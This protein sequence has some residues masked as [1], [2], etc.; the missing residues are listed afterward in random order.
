MSDTVRQSIASVYE[1]QGQQYCRWGNRGQIDYVHPSI[2]NLTDFFDF[3]MFFRISFSFIILGPGPFGGP[4]QGCT[5]LLALLRHYVGLGQGYQVY[6]KFLQIGIFWKG[7]GALRRPPLEPMANYSLQHLAWK[8]VVLLVL[9]AGRRRSELSALSFEDGCAQWG[10]QVG[11]L[12][13]RVGV[14]A[15]VLA[16]RDRSFLISPNWWVFTKRREGRFLCPLRALKGH[17]QRMLE[18]RR[19]GKHM[20]MCYIEGLRHVPASPMTISRWIVETVRFT[21]RAVVGKGGI[22]FHK[23]RVQSE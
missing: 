7:L 9:A 23:V 14:M 3:L 16:N 21:L 18:S 10:D 11:Y 22:P 20:F 4:D 5:R 2:T 8:T 15:R 13:T 12:K 17:R 6:V 1:L 19:A